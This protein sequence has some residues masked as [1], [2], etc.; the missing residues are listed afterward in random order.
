MNE[1]YLLS[2]DGNEI[3]VECHSSIHIEEDFDDICTIVNTYG[4]R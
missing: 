4:G 3:P 1:A 2:I